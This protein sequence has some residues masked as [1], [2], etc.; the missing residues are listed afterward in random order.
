MPAPSNPPKK[1][2]TIDPQGKRAA[3]LAAAEK[4]FAAKGYEATSIADIAAEAD[5]AVG[6]VYRLFADKA[7]LLEA[8]HASM[9]EHLVEAMNTAW[10]SSSAPRMQ[11]FEAMY[12]AIFDAAAELA[13][14]MPVYE[15]TH[16]RAPEDAARPRERVVRAI[17]AIYSDAAASGELAS[18]PTSDV[19][20]IMHGLV[21]GGMRT[22]MSAPTRARR[23]E[24]VALLAGLTRRAFAPPN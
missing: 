6:S 1:A 23:D 16:H 7:A 5:V 3:V 18:H 11:R 9:E 12:G 20:H 22:W 2:R 24:L 4:Q 17:E 15:M 21:E 13:R 8:L 10:F 14:A 19:A